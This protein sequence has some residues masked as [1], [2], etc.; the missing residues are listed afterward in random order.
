[1]GIPDGGNRPLKVNV[2]LVLVPVTITD[3]MN[4][5]VRGLGRDSFQVLEEKKEQEIRYFSSE[6]QRSD[7]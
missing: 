2:N 1:M 4:R 6:D 7:R 5:L 3:G